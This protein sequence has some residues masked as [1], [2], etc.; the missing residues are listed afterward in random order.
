MNIDIQ[1]GKIELDKAIE[2]HIQRKLNLGLSKVHSHIESVQISLSDVAGMED[3]S[4]KHCE[5]KFSF[6]NMADL[7][8]EETQ[9]D[10]YCAIDRAVQ[11]SSRAI[12]RKLSAG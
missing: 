8:I 4:K 7:V 12:A 10:L 5:V 1:A 9:T 2:M 3:V 11:K 6:F